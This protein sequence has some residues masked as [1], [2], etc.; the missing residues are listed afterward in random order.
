MHG[1]QLL[2]KVRLGERGRELLELMKLLELL[3]PT[4]LKAALVIESEL[5]LEIG[6]TLEV[7]KLSL[8][9]RFAAMVRCGAPGRRT[10]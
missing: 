7:S 6:D 1:W 8:E 10:T 5:L 3:E 9:R 4:G 2:D